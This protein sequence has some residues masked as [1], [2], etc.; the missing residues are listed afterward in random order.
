MVCNQN[1]TTGID[2][3]QPLLV[4]DGDCGF[5]RFWL[6]KWQKWT[7]YRIPSAPY[8]SLDSQ[9]PHINPDSFSKAVYLIFPDGSF[10]FGVRAI[11]ESFGLVN[12]HRWLLWSYQHIPG[13]APIAEASYRF[14]AT[15]RPQ[16]GRLTKLLFSSYTELSKSD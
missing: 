13:L 9:Y 10:H 15:H 2:T 6:S 3:T 4:W 14:V 11:L 1:Q 8:Q 5:C 16:F 7:W 12:R